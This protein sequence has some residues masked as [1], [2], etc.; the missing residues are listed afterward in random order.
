MY[1]LLSIQ[2]YLLPLAAASQKIEYHVIKLRNSTF[3]H[4]SLIID[5][6]LQNE[7]AYTT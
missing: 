4:H 2:A 3:T 1:P 5:R 7:M 6:K